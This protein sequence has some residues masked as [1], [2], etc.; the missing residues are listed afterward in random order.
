MSDFESWQ[1]NISVEVRDSLNEI[2]AFQWNALSSDGNPFLH[3]TFLHSLETTGCM[4]QHNG[5]YPRYVFLWDELNGK[6]LLGALP[7]YLKTNSYGE[8]VFD[9][10]WAEAYERHQLEYYPKRVSSIPFTPATGPRIL[11]RNDIDDTDR[12]A[13]LQRMLCMA[14]IQY[15]VSENYSSVHWLFLTDTDCMAL[16]TVSALSS[17]SDTKQENENQGADDE[18]ET[19]FIL[20]RIDCQYHWH[21]SNYADFDEFLA[22]CTSKRRKTIR[23]ERRYVTDE[24]IRI[25]RRAGSSLSETE[26]EWVHELY[27]STFDRKWGNPS[28]TLDFFKRI[29]IDF[30]GNVLIVFAYDDTNEEPDKPIACSVMFVGKSVLYG[31]YWGCREQRHSLHF[32]LCYYQG[33]EFCIEQQLATFEPGAQGEHK[34]TRGFVPTIT[35]SAHFIAHQGFREAIADFLDE[36]TRHVQLR[37]EGLANLLPFKHGELSIKQ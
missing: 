32:E 8:F 18:R 30:G 20:R 31:R 2:D 13:V 23:R 16:D 5:W 37:C 3:Y 28:L 36:E 24:Q 22:T 25:E 9:W 15:C 11:V 33:I 27:A 1:E 12:R 35:H 10:A 26:W 34:I 21:N 6:E 29:G 14:A 17:V 7:L 19:A 4:G